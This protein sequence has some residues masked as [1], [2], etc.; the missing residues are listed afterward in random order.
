MLETLQTGE[1]AQV[2]HEQWDEEGNPTY[3]TLETYPVKGEGGEVKRI[4]EIRRDITKELPSR[5]EMR[6]KELKT[7]L[8]RLVQEDRM[9]S[10]GKLSASCAHEINN[11]IQGLLTFAHL[12]Q[13]ILSKKEPRQ[14]DLEEFKGYLKL[15]SDEL[16]RCGNIVSGLLSFSRE[17]SMEAR[18]VDLNDVLRSVITLTAHHMELHDITLDLELSNE[19]LNIRGDVNQLQQCFL[20]LFFNAIEA[21]EDGGTLSITSRFAAAGPH[22]EVIVRDTGCGIPEEHADKIFDPF[23]TTK[24]EGKGTGLGLSIVYGIV[25]AHEG[26]IKI[27]S[28]PGEGTTVR[29]VFPACPSP[30][31]GGAFDE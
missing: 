22:A 20:N 5:W 26:E 31:E 19:P 28:E 24:P 30:G 1:R 14:E 17:S 18:E 12:M 7:D 2:I 29:L 15:M 13:S 16:E 27:H 6:L 8:G 9:L 3:C 21:T 10:L 4:I 25:K 23:F 11:P